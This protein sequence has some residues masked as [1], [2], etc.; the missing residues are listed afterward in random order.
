MDSLAMPS[1]FAHWF[2]RILELRIDVLL[3]PN[4]L[5]AELDT[6]YQRLKRSGDILYDLPSIDIAMPGF[7][8]RYREA[9]GEHYVY[10]EDVARGRLA[11]YTVFNRLIELG[12][13]ADP[14]LRAP[15]SKYAAPYQRR[16][17]AAAIYRWWLDR[18]HCLISGARQSAGANALWHS[19]SKHYELVYVD[20]RNKSLNCLGH[21]VDN[22]TLEDLHT[23]MILIGRGWN[24]NELAAAARM[25]NLIQEKHRE[26]SESSPDLSC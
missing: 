9:D 10:V 25:G 18:N 2:S 1:P 23:R 13:R 22:A 11:G 8:F 14:H 5:E 4:E 19:L 21:H 16:G 26:F 15:H 7:L 6:L 3:P 24:L 20:L 17:I 12:R